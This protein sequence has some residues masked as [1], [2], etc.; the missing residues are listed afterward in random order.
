FAVGECV[1]HNGTCYGLVAPLFEQGK[2]LAATITGNRGPVYGGTIQAAKLKIMGVDVFSA[3]KFSEKAPGTD[4]VRYEDPARGIYKKLTVSDGKR[5]GVILVGDIS[6]SHRYFFLSRRRRHT[7]SKRDW[8]SDVCSSDL[9][10]AARGAEPAP[11]AEAAAA[12]GAPKKKK[13]RKVIKKSDMLDTMERD[14]MR[15]GKRPQKRR[16]LPGKEQ[17]KT[18]ITVPRASKR[19]IRISE[20]I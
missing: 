2:V 20:V 7:R 1:E 6:D 3:G 4:A 16:A 11:G 14:F 18:E 13:G 17:K 5:A 19:V 15:G 9:S 12:D 10:P 8:S